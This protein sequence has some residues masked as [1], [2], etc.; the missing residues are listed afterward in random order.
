MADHD[1]H[2]PVTAPSVDGGL[3]RDGSE[4][5]RTA[6]IYQVYPRSFADADGDGTGDLA[7]IASRLDHLRDLGVDAVWI[8][9]FYPSPQADGGYDVADYHDVDPLF[10]SLADADAL[11]ARAH[12]LGLR[13][14][15]DL[16]PNHTSDQHP[17][18]Q[19][20]L[21]APAGS[22][23]RARYWFVESDGLPNN[24][25]SDFGGPAWTQL[26]DGQW[27]L[28]L[29]DSR[30]PDLNWTNPEVRVMFLEVLRF[31][32]DRG[33]DGF[34]VDVAH[35]LVK[36]EGLPDFDGDFEE[37]VSGL[38]PTSTAPFYDQDGVHEIWREWRAVL[39]RYPG[40]RA[41]VA[42]AWVTPMDRLAEYVRPDEF[43]QAFNFTFLQQPWEAAG[44][45]R[46]IAESLRTNG[47]VGAPPT[48][49]LSNHDV[50]RTV[51]RLGFAAAM[52]SPWL[53]AGGPAPDLAL[54]VRRA[55]A[56]TVL[57]LALPGAAYL[58][59]GEELGLPEVIDL[60]AA[61]RQ[62]PTFRRTGG[63]LLGRDGCRVPIPWQH[64]A[65]A[66]GFSSTGKAWLPQPEEF[67]PLAVDQQRGV[68]GSTL[69]L[70]RRLLA[71]RRGR[72][73]GSGRLE[74][75]DLGP[76]LVAFDTTTDGVGATRVVVNLGE[77]PYRLPADAHVLVA[78]TALGDEDQG[79][80]RLL[81]RDT[82]VWIELG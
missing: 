52:V 21:A 80:G 23:A 66:F 77:A 62:D 78:S 49:V 4:W 22:P 8:S 47:S 79:G 16:V 2:A 46:T 48:W 41:M 10:G 69:E 57:M 15:V 82:A 3:A 34:R 61:A 70:Y 32:L 28:H 39:D 54:G 35:A 25:P 67:G 64:A 11:V 59:Q 36:A 42:E 12:E 14:F 43:H 55:R 6:V 37:L 7:G 45:R 81:A 50:V 68:D 38:V 27:Y 74:L 56:A 18:F 9:P 75:V 53:P 63:E 5:W 26:P 13:V 76:E 19:E 60:P 58:Y 71:Q 51:T 33:I 44:W 29:F 73:M 72:G 17:W 24:W 20:A 40:E 65:P 30:Q 31:W 1:V